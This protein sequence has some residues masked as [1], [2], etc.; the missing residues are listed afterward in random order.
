MAAVVRLGGIRPD[1][2]PS[3]HC[4]V[5]AFILA[6]DFI[7]KRRRFWICLGPC[8]LLW[9]S[10]VYLRYHYL[11]D[12]LCGFLLAAGALALAERTALSLQAES[13]RGRAR[14]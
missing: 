14:R 7:H 10:T 13:C 2:F 3:L 9:F 1:A 11:V 12:V 5:P 8:V 6:F 4:A